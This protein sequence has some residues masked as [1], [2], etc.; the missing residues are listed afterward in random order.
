MKSGKYALGNYFKT[1][2]NLSTIRKVLVLQSDRITKFVV[3]WARDQMKTL[4][5][6]PKQKSNQWKV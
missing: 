3:L 2:A 6:I 1:E 5:T 4:I